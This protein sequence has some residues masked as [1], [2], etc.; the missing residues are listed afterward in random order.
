MEQWGESLKIQESSQTANENYLESAPL[1]RGPF[2]EYTLAIS[3]LP[4]P[5]Q[6]PRDKKE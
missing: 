6:N 5:L 1:K 2:T 3:Y 4:N